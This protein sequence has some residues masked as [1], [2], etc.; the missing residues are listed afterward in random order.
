MNGIRYPVTWTTT[1]AWSLSIPLANGTNLLAVQG[2]DRN[3][4]RRTNATDTITVTNTGSGA[5]RPVVINEWM[6]DNN[7]PNGFA[8]RA[9]GL[10]QDWFEL[11]NP[12]TNAVNLAGFFL[13]DNLSEPAK[14]QIPPGTIIASGDFL[15]VCTEPSDVAAPRASADGA[16]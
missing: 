8:D 5:L 13:T 15:L 16:R 6:A 2:V 14:W 7:G 3:G 4:L 9:D 11:F 10:F 1:T 12:N